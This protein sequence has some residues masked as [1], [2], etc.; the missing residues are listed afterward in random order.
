MPTYGRVVNGVVREVITAANQAE[1]DG[2]YHADIA[3]QFVLDPNDEIANKWTWDGSNFAAPVPV[4]ATWD[5]V[6]LKQKNMIETVRWHIE[7]HVTQRELGMDVGVGT[8]TSDIDEDVYQDLLQYIQDIRED[9]DANH[10][11]PQDALDALD[12]LVSPV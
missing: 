2:K 10:A 6:Q 5:D 8:N 7:R 3:S 1:I 9:D 4:A 11:T 12:A